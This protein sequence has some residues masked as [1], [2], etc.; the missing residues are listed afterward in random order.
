MFLILESFQVPQKEIYVT[1]RLKTTHFSMYRQ[2]LCSSLQGAENVKT[3][4]LKQKPAFPLNYKAFAGMMVLML[5][6]L[7]DITA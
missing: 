3:F 1:A 7:Y 2:Q 4:V 6:E 5:E